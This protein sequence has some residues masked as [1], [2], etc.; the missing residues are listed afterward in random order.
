M[1]EIV[2]SVEFDCPAEQVFAY[3]EAVER[4]G[5]WQDQLVSARKLTDGPTGVGTRVEETRRL[6][7]RET[8][9]T[10]EITEHE[11]PRLFA[12]RGLDG[13]IRPVGRG[14]VEPLDDGSRSRLTLTLD[15]EASGMG[16]LMLPLVQGAASKQ[17]VADS[18]KMKAKL[19]S[20]A[21]T[22]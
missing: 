3:L 17:V 11:P 19:E 22:S 6:G 15:F 10:Y 14:V 4:H 13:P 16:K 20:E 8:Q 18:L 5:E 9:L 2:N 12:F 1:T 7:G 21:A